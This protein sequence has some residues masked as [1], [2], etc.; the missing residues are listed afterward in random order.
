MGT[1]SD[2]VFAAMPVHIISSLNRPITERVL[3]IVLMGF[4]VIA[5][6]A[7]VMKIYHISA[8]NPRHAILRDWVPL[9]WWYRV[10]EIGLIVAACAPFLKPLIGRVIHRF[11]TPQFDFQTIGL[12]TIRSK[13]VGISRENKETGLPE[14]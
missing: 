8:W 14:Y 13:E 5:A 6:V 10:E 1:L 9:L 12:N 7:G 4:G 2:L 11:G 3:V